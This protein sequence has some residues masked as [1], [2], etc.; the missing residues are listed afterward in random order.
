MFHM[1]KKRNSEEFELRHELRSARD[2]TKGI[3]IADLEKHQAAAFELNDELA[4]YGLV[5][6]PGNQTR[7]SS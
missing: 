4:L 7:Q 6:K 3:T 2:L 1:Y 5:R